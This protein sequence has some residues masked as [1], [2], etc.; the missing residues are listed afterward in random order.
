MVCDA[1]ARSIYLVVP[2]LSGSCPPTTIQSQA[3]F[4]YSIG[5]AQ[6]MAPKRGEGSS[7]FPEN[8]EEGF[9]LGQNGL[10]N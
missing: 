9:F 2:R 7:P 3:G 4:A 6:L 10:F 5:N 1:T 8:G